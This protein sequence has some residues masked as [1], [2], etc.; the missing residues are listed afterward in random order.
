MKSISDNLIAEKNKLST[1]NAWVM[2]MEVTLP[3]TTVLRFAQ[4]TEA[5]TFDGNVYSAANMDLGPL[6]EDDSGNL[7]SLPLRISNVDETLKPYLRDINGGVGSIVTFRQVSTGHLGESYSNLEY[8]F[9][10][11]S[12]ERTGRDFSCS[13]GV[14]QILRQSFPPDRFRG[15]HCSWKFESEECGYV[16]TAIVGMTLSGTDPVSVELTGHGFSTG[17]SIRLDSITGF[18]PDISGTYVITKTDPD[19]FTLDDT[20]SSDYTG[21]FSAG[22]AG[23]AACR[24]ILSDCRARSNSAR[25]G[26]FVGMRGGGIRVA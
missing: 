3:D 26:G 14:P 12:A 22:T 4:N 20:D 1:P 17:N 19:N 15:D 10:I 13:L 8:T 25:F 21:S 9:D 7:S 5:V 11:L 16:Q 18:T 23:F 2:L 24:R 6:T